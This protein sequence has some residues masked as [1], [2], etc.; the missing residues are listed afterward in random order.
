MKSTSFKIS[1]GTDDI[2]WMIDMYNA[3][4]KYGSKVVGQAVG[5]I[6]W[7]GSKSAEVA[8]ANLEIVFNNANQKLGTLANHPNADIAQKA[9]ALRDM[10]PQV[11]H[12]ANK[13]VGLADDAF[14]VLGDAAQGFIKAGL[15]GLSFL[16][17]VLKFLGLWNDPK[18]QLG[19]PVNETLAVAPRDTVRM[20]M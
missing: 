20:Y 15:R 9:Q 3:V 7:L 17:S 1:S 8:K 12:F 13:G 11:K 16:G 6:M 4:T 18:A 14:T 2:Q 5:Q 10:M 19:Q